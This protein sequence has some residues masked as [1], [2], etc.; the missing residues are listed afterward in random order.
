MFKNAF[1]LSVVALAF[2]AVP[3]DADASIFRNISDLQ[4]AEVFGQSSIF[5]GFGLLVGTDINGDSFVTGTAF[6][7]EDNDGLAG[8]NWLATAG[9]T[10][11]SAPE[12]PW[13]RLRFFNNQD[14]LG[15]DLNDFIEIDLTVPFPGFTGS[16]PNGGTGNDIGL[17]RLSTAIT[18]VAPLQFFQGSDNDLIGAEFVTA[19]YGN[20][21]VFG[22]QI[23]DF[24]GI[25]RGGRNVVESAGASF[26]ATTVEDQFFVTDFDQFD[27]EGPLPL[28]HQASNSDSGAGLLFNIDGSLVVGGIINGGLTSNTSTFAISTAPFNDFINTTISSSSTSVPEPGT[29]SLLAFGMIGAAVKRNRK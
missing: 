15:G 17:A 10:L 1:I 25:R 7:I 8:S 24:D 2:S 3:Q 6:L 9:H 16:E 11:F 4:E 28:E 26:G 27:F 22:Q 5:D 12:T 14:V 13:E 23:G 29:M 19:G 21:G 20:P 18:D